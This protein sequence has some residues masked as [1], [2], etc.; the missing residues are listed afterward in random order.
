MAE[1]VATSVGN[2]D[3][4]AGLSVAGLMLPEAVAYAGIAGLPPQHAVVAAIVGCL[5]YSILGRSRFAIVSPTSSS[6][7]ILAATIA[8]LPG[9][10]A[11][12][13]A[14]VTVMVA[15]TGLLFVAASL[16]RLGNLA[17]FISRPVL[18]GFAFGLAVTIIVRQLPTVT[19]VE[20]PATDII[21]QIAGLFA[22]LPR[23]N[24]VSIAVG[25]AALAALLLL[26]RAPFLPGAFLVLCAGILASR[27]LDLAGHGVAVVG[28]LSISM[29][30]PSLS[31]VEWSQIRQL[32]P[33]TL[34]LVLI[35]FAESW[36]TIR[37]LSLRHG[38]SVTANRELLALGA[39]NVACAIAQGMPVG[40]GFSAGSAAEAAGAQTRMTALVA[41]VG[42]ALLVVLGA[43]LLQS[44]P[45]PVLSAVVIA[46]LAHALDPRPLLR[47]WKLKHDVVIALAAAVGVIAFGVVN[48][49]TIAVALS[50]AVLLHRLATPYVASLGRLG[51]GHDFVDVARHADA[52]TMPGIAIWRPAQPLFFAN[53]DAILTETA[54]RIGHDQTARAVIL[55]LEE[56]FDLDSTALDALIEFDTLVRAQ[57]K[58]LY[59]ARVH[60]RV[61]D[62]I[63]LAAPPLLTYLSYSVDDAVAAASQPETTASL[64]GAV[65]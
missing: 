52:Q 40:A 53:A 59:Y 5:T 65:R 4:I 31:L 44:L 45:E 7:A 14:L 24:M 63:A 60:D 11:D 62:M 51:Q 42:L 30:L 33:Y 2:R 25:V 64:P 61:R 6:A 34:P 46:A 57:G 19:G 39:A 17:S 58:H 8:A 16:L 12:K 41:A 26:R 38:E 43:D 21:H 28:P 35:L 54:A 29:T 47:L 55:S 18:R 36:G 23:W 13:M 20:V 37:S 27:L 1:E 15:L 32:V 56:S 49:I 10:T 48:G 9:S 3:W 22:A 50:L